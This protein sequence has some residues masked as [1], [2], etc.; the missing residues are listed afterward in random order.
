YRYAL[1]V[2]DV[3][4]RFV[5]AVPI[6]TKSNDE[7][8]KAFTTIYTRKNGKLKYPLRKLEVDAGAEFKGS[9][10]RF[11]NKKDIYIRVAMP[12]RHRQQALVERK[13]QTIGHVLQ[14]RMAAQELVT[15]QTSREWVEFLPRVI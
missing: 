1:V 15:G 10:K 11:F 4:S 12:G 14:Q 9:V 5:D 6:K 3:G 2:V 8:I 13:N 7:I